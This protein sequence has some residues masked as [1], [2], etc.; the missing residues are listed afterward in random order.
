MLPPNMVRTT[1]ATTSITIAMTTSSS[2]SLIIKYTQLLYKKFTQFG[3]ANLIL[4]K[5]FVDMIFTISSISI[6][7]DRM[8]QSFS[9]IA[10]LS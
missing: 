2:D 10:E 8:S 1:K 5:E 3:S 6:R 9:K 4:E 7:T